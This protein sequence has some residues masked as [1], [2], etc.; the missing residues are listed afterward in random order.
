[1]NAF[2]IENCRSVMN[3]VDDMNQFNNDMEI[4]RQRFQEV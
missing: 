1:M 3:A 4:Y 2:T